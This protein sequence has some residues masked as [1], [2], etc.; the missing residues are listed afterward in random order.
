MNSASEATVDYYTTAGRAVNTKDRKEMGGQLDRQKL[1][2]REIQQEYDA[3]T[4]ELKQAAEIFGFTSNE[5]REVW[6]KQN[7]IAQALTE[8]RT[9]ELELTHAIEELRFTVR[10]FKIERLSSFVEKL[11]NIASL[12]EKR[13]TNNAL[14]YKVTE[15]PYVEQLKYNNDLIVKYAEDLE[16][17]KKEI[18]RRT[19]YEGLEVDSEEYQNLYNEIVKDEQQLYNLY[20]ANE[21]LKMSIRNLRWEEYKKFQET[22]EKISSDFD[23]I[24]SFIREGEVLDDDG[25]FTE[26]GFAQ[27]ALI[28]EDMDVATKKIAG[29]RGAI[30]KLNEELEL[31]TIN[32]ET[33]GQ[34]F[35]EQ[36]K[37]IQ[38]AA[39]EAYDDMQKLA[40][41][42]IK[43][44][45]AEND[46]LQELIKK[47]QES[48]SAKKA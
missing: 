13:G 11:G 31:G 8:S 29:A 6:T 37:I 17:R 1:I 3:Y 38:G 42:Y 48:L 14:G 30:E 27:I 32:E 45:T 12:A 44:I 46:I 40:D 41:L 26:R 23:H 7:E 43:Q 35:E 24:Q 22:L 5:Y 10:G 25:Q 4:K 21:D 20:S 34:E 19:A 36:M 47:R 9:A 16:D 2:T 18:A 28:G 33:F 39:S 15:D